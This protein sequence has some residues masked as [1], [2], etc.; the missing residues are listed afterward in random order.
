MSKSGGEGR[1]ATSEPGPIL[2]LDFDLDWDPD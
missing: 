2:T 1:P